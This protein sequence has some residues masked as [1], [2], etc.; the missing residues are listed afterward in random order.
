VVKLAAVAVWSAL[1]TVLNPVLSPVLAGLNR[2]LTWLADGVYAA[3]AP[4]PG[5]LGLV[6]LSAV[7]GVLLLVAFRYTSNQ[8]ALGRARD[9]ITAH[10]LA[11]KLYQDELRVTFR[12]QWRLL[13]ALARLQ[14]HFLRPLL[15]LALPMAL[16][17]GQMGLRYQWRPLRPGERTLIRL[18]LDGEVPTA[19]IRLEPNPACQVEVGPVPGGGWLVWRVRAVEPGRHALAFDLGGTR[20]TKELVIAGRGPQRIC[21]RRP[22]RDWTAQV[23]YP[24]EP[25]LPAG[26]GARSIEID[27]PVTPAGVA[28]ANWWLLTFFVVSMAAALVFKPVFRV[29]F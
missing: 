4:L 29:R 15:I 17:L 10:L 5:W 25:R 28:G 20:V 7:A 13:K 2:P 12:S 18:R 11:L 3:L 22:G 9:A 19:S 6:L 27:Y 1:D 24:A 14:Y 23:L 16:G 8:A 21:P 26:A